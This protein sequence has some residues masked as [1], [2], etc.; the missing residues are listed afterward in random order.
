[1][2]DLDWQAGARCADRPEMLRWFFG[3]TADDAKVAKEFCLGCPVMGLCADYALTH[4]IADGVWG[5]TSPRDRR[6]ILQARRRAELERA[7]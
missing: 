3:E 1:M 4:R 5:A 7:S 6:K 2:S